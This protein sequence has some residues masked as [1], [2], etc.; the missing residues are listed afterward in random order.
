MNFLEFQKIKQ[1]KPYKS[2]PCSLQG[3]KTTLKLMKRIC[4]LGKSR[5]YDQRFIPA[6]EAFNY[7]LYKY[8]A[9]NTINHAQI[10][11]EK[12]NI[13][14]Q[15]N[16]LAIK[17]LKRLLEAETLSDQDRA[18]ASAMLAQAYINTNAIDSAV[19]PIRTAAN[20]TKNK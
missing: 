6:L 15:N 13:R 12:T 10:W 17:N 8:P 16:E 11:R 18:D 20:F 1:Q 4:F 5:Y 3:K 7:I 9:S 14:L 19:V 2:I